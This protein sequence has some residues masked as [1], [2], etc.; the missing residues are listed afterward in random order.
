MG[1]IKSQATSGDHVPAPQTSRVFET[2]E[3]FHKVSGHFKWPDT[4]RPYFHFKAKCR[5]TNINHK[6]SMKYLLQSFTLS[7]L[8]MICIS[9]S[10]AQKKEMVQ[11][12]KSAKEN[13]IN[14]F[15][16]DKLFTS[17]L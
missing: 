1:N 12:I 15:I 5:R 16:G 8:A 3:V 13:K 6:N 2:C 10:F 14:I 7:L 17:F 4:C 11:V 9:L